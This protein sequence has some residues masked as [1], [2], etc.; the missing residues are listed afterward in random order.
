MQKGKI[1]VLLKW[2]LF[3]LIDLQAYWNDHHCHNELNWKSDNTNYSAF[4]LIVLHFIP[5]RPPIRLLQILINL[6]EWTSSLWVNYYKIKC[7]FTWRRANALPSMCLCVCLECIVKCPLLR[8]QE[9]DPN[10][11]WRALIG[12]PLNC[13]IN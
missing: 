3:F 10:A 7:T 6:S 1:V 11:I 2:F 5:K 9:S 4:Y 13:L 8:N 12:N